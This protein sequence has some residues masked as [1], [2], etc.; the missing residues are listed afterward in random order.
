[1]TTPS[2]PP[3]PPST[4]RLPLDLGDVEQLLDVTTTL[5]EAVLGGSPRAVEIARGIMLRQDGPSVVEGSIPGASD[6]PMFHRL[7]DG[8]YVGTHWAA[9]A[10]TMSFVR[11]LGSAEN[12]M[13]LSMVDPKA[14]PISVTVQRIGKKTPGT[15]VRETETKLAKVEKQLEA[16]RLE[17]AETALRARRLCAEAL[18][19]HAQGMAA[20][21]PDHDH[22]AYNRAAEIVRD[23]NVADAVRTAFERAS[24]EEAWT[25]TK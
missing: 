7:S 24:A 21:D 13:E 23:V 19:A 16:S 4:A 22:S 8:T 12:Y 1:M 18:E 3:S 11:T 17:L 20:N 9:R 14:G 5:A 15:L 2:Q 10:L 25:K 6:E